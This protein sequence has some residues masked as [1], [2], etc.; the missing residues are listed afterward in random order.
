MRGLTCLASGMAVD[1][2]VADHPDH[3]DHPDLERAD[4]LTVLK[5]G[6]LATAQRRARPFD[7]A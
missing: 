6:A 5:F 7:A 3:P 1:D 4:L 2:I